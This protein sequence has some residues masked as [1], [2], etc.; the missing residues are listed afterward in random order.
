MI[1]IPNVAGHTCVPGGVG[2]D[3]CGSMDVYEPGPLM[4][5]AILLPAGSQPALEATCAARAEHVVKVSTTASADC[6]QEGRRTER[7][8]W[9]GIPNVELC[10][11]RAGFSDEHCRRRCDGAGGSAT[12]TG[13][14]QRA[15]DQEENELILKVPKMLICQDREWL[16]LPLMM[17][18]ESS[19]P[20]PEPEQRQTATPQG[21][22]ALAEVEMPGDVSIH[23]GL[24]IS[25]SRHFSGTDIQEFGGVLVPLQ[26]PV[27]PRTRFAVSD[28]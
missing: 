8:G 23:G 2:R 9:S 15:H 28:T 17:R 6:E 21:Y 27:A 5:Y 12:S 14:Q 18:S 10:Q 24:S 25:V 22:V 19:S 11:Q 3:A 20:A 1:F 26:S 16:F 4:L 7:W 13:T